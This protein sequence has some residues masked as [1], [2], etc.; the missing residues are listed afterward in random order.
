MTHSPLTIPSHLTD[1]Q[2]VDALKRCV[3]YERH[4]TASL[5]AHL[6]EMDTRLIHLREG[7][8][9]LFVYC[10]EVLGLSESATYKRIEVARA[11]RR[12]PV[13]LDLLSQ[14]RLNLTTARLV[15]P[16]LTTENHEE[17]LA[18]IAGLGKRAV[19]ELIAIRFPKPDVAPLIR[20]LPTPQGSL[21]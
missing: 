17:L 13:V 15:A 10:C 7:C 19:E 16:H 3:R 4:A 14:G 1:V 5:I 11:V 20:K 12:F 18:A 8:S 6:A 21:L 9:S 2:L